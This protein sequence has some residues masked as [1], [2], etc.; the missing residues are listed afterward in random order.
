MT[1]Q[2]RIQG[3]WGSRVQAALTPRERFGLLVIDEPH[4]RVPAY[5]LVTSHAAFVAKMKLQ[6]Y[7]TR[8]RSM[9]RAQL[10][11]QEQYGH[12]FISIFSEVG[13]IAEALGSGFEY[14]ADD[15]PVLRRPRLGSVAE[16]SLLSE[17][18]AATAGRFPVYYEAI[19]YAYEAV[20]DRI[21]ILAFVPAPFTTA[22]H[23]VNGEDFLLALTLKP[24]SAREL[25]DRVTEVTIRFLREIVN[26]GAL[27][28]LVDP[29]AS[30]SVISPRT[31]REFALPAER[32]LIDFLH[33]YDLDITLHI[34]GDTTSML[35]LLKDTGADLVSL[36]QV[37]LTEAQRVIGD[38]QRL[39]GNYNT[40][41]LLL[42]TPATIEQEVRAMT[43]A[44]AANPKGYIAATGC[45]VPVRTP[46]ENVRA[47][48]RGARPKSE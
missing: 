42:N 36:D 34:C 7:C 4:D 37:D 28:M 13:I 20:G 11:A 48:I 43:A 39:I 17:P 35:S 2:G 15:L 24:E 31:Y 3:V 40:S 8:G 26:H 45:E 22:L 25:L 30:G 19:E 47:F 41:C 23:L 38:S 14:P 29:L 46:P 27:P 21:P 16:V 12:D 5:P 33:R 44:G 1:K 32:R 18:D 10:M 9:A 6:E